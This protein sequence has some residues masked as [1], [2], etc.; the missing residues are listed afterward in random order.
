[1]A[2]LEDDHRNVIYYT[3]WSGFCGPE[4][5]DGVIEDFLLDEPELDEKALRAEVA[6]QMA[7]KAK[8]E[9][10][11]P[12]VTDCDKLD[13]AFAALADAKILGLHSA[14]YTMS[15]GHDEAAEALADE[16][17]GA[18]VGYCFYHGQD[19]ESALDSGDAMFIA[20]DHVDGDVPD[21]VAV[22]ETVMAALRA[23]GLKPDWNGD[24]KRRIE[25]KD[26][27]WRRRYVPEEV[28]A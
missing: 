27:V 8:D 26:F 15:D 1:M 28:D 20:Y 5:V 6:E 17:E 24:A 4:D 3:I 22:G 23:A 13:T 21:K 25:L 14:G 7:K 12:E 10:L 16:P 9:Q 18:F 19:I 11:W 2:A